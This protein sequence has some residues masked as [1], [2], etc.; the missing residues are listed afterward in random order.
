MLINID[1]LLNPK[2]L[3]ILRSMGHGDRIV[4]CDANFPAISLAKRFVRIDGANIPR[5][6][7]AILSVMPLDSFIEYPAL[8]M[9]IDGKPD[10]M[11]ETHKEFIETTKDIAGPNW[12][13]GSMERFQFYKESKEAF[14]IIATSDQRPYSCFMMTKGV[15]KSDGN[16]WK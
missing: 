15:I 6:A 16:V 11:N 5:T 9:E 1:P 13:V 2:L 12:K 8:R 4:L 14:A 7:K 3:S 10:E